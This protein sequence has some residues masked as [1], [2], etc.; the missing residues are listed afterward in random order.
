M[1]TPAHVVIK[2]YDCFNLIEELGWYAHEAELKA[3]LLAAE[4][5][6]ATLQAEKANGFD[7]DGTA[8]STKEKNKLD[9]KIDACEA[10]IKKT[11][12]AITKNTVR[13][14]DLFKNLMGPL[15]EI[16]RR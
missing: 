13:A 2:S 15:K 14:E 11:R 8:L 4:Q 6:L 10:M 16:V 3:A 5:S 7:A 12:A 1:P 9:E